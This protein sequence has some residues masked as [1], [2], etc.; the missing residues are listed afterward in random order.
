MPSRP[1]SQAGW[2]TKSLRGPR[3]RSTS[4]TATTSAAHASTRAAD[5]SRSRRRSAPTPW[6]RLKDITRIT[7]VGAAVVTGTR[8]PMPRRGTARHPRVMGGGP[9]DRPCAGPPGWL[10]A[11][12]VGALVLGVHLFLDLVAGVG[13]AILD[14]LF[15][16]VGAVLDVLE[17]L[18]GR[19]A[20][21]VLV[22]ATGGRSENED[23]S[24]STTEKT[25]ADDV[26]G[27]RLPRP[28]GAK[29]RQGMFSSWPCRFTAC[30]IACSGHGRG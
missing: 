17:L 20:V 2:S 4:W 11:V 30:S 16:L 18:V 29:P 14:V 12:L 13:H 7:W 22:V 23:P 10:L 21:A 3:C 9:S 25:L 24:E 6:W 28:T 5:R 27:P 26:H 1:A 8:C 19:P 15:H